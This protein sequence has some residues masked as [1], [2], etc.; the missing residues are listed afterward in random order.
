MASGRRG[1]G[2]LGS[3]RRGSDLMRVTTVGL[4]DLGRSPRMQYHAEALALSAADVD[5][6]AYEGE[7][8]DNIL[9]DRSRITMHVLTSGRARSVSRALYLP[10][11]LLRVLAQTSRLLSL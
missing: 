4:G 7:T 6:V 11:A 9:G 8:P 3:S 2:M 5:V 1:S 10:H